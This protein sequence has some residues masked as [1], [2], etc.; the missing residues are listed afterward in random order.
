M[1]SERELKRMGEK[2]L[3]KIVAGVRGK[4]GKD[5]DLPV[6]TAKGDKLQEV[7]AVEALR[8]RESFT[9]TE[10]E[11][12]IADGALIYRPLAQTIPTQREKQTKK[13]KKS[14]S[15]VVDAGDRI[16]AVPSRPVEFAIYPAPDRFFV[17]G[18]FDRSVKQEERDVAGD[19]QDLRERLGLENITE[20]IPDE[21]STLSDI[22]FQH[23]DATGRWLFG[24]EY[25]KAQGLD[26]VYG[27]TKNAT[28]PAGSLVADV[29]NAK[30]DNG[31][32]VGGW[33][34]DYGRR[35]VGAV[36]LVV[37]VEVK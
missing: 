1:H 9:D 19:A 30:A 34:R 16:N 32:D 15:Y 14:F 8:L 18:S 28:N 23:L 21:A 31:L 3:A 4:L 33:D 2:D 36:R 26:W 10:W 5:I 12:L 25:A 27:R 35:N 37:P 6:T 24:P 17:P 22:T 13:G 7:P 29:G 20:I 11:A